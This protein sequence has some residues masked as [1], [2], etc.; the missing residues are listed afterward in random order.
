MTIDGHFIIPH[1]LR[2]VLAHSWSF[3]A[4]G[5]VRGSETPCIRVPTGIFFTLPLHSPSE[6]P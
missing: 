4:F 5:V 3:R 2:L 1:S 6:Q